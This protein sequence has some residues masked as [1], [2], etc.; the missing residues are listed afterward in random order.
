[1]AEHGHIVIVDQQDEG[2]PGQLL[3][4][5][6]KQRS[7][8]TGRGWYLKR[9]GSAER[10]DGGQQLALKLRERGATGVELRKVQAQY[11]VLTLILP[12]RLDV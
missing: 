8:V 5:R 6:L 1:M 12:P 4:Q 2:A 7:K 9:M 10:T 11:E 3:E